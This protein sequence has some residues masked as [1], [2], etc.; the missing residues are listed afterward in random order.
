MIKQIIII[1]T[2]ISLDSDVR[3]VKNLNINMR[4]G[5]HSGMVLSGIIGVHKWQFDIWS[6]DSI[7]ASSMEHDGVPG[8]VHVTKETLDLVADNYSAM[9][10]YLIEGKFFL[11]CQ[12][13]LHH[14]FFRKER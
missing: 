12:K 7:L 10:K 2:K 9:Q 5:I 3:K 6:Q 13:S 11:K 1:I 4:I 14:L 8:F